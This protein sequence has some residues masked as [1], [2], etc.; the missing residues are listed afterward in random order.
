MALKTRHQPALID[1]S[2]FV[3]PGAIIVGDVTIGAASSVWFN[4]VLRGDSDQIQI[5]Q[6]CNIQDGAILHVDPGFPISM[7][8]GVTIGHGAIVHGSTIL[9]NALVGMGAILLNGSQIGE[10]S[11]V[12]A[13]AVVT[14]KDF[15]PAVLILGSPARAVR[16]LRHEE[17]E[18]NRLAALAY[19]ER[20]RA[21]V[22]D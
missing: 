9:S 11:I 7:G 20:A 13:G 19:V 14:G 21:F 15:P 4:A 17:I 22:A 10:D 8:T 1:P 5:G 6:R 3:A 2:A 12:G 16:E 18:A